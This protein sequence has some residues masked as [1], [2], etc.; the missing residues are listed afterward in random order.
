MRKIWL[1]SLIL[2]ACAAAPAGA[3]AA[4]EL[5]L[6]RSTV[7]AFR[8]DSSQVVRG[9]AVDI[10]HQALRSA[11]EEPEGRREIDLNLFPDTQL[12]VVIDRIAIDWP[13][14]KSFVG[15]VKGAA[16]SMVILVKGGGILAGKV[17]FPGKVFALRYAQE[18]TQVVEELDANAYPD[19]ELPLE[20]PVDPV[21][22]SSECDWQ[23]V[24]DG[25]LIDA[26][27][28]YDG[29]ARRRAGGTVAMRN[30]I[31]LAVA[32]ANEILANSNVVARISVVHMTEVAY[33]EGVS[34]SVLIR[35]LQDPADGVLDEVHGIRDR[36]G[37]DLVHF[38]GETTV[39]GCGRGYV[40]PRAST[41]FAP[42]AFAY[43]SRA[44][45]AGTFVV[46]HEMGH[47]M[48]CGHAPGDPGAFG[49]FRYSRGYKDP[50]QAFR[51]VM[52]YSCSSFCP[53]APYFSNPDVY[54]LG[55][56]T[57]RAVQ[58]NATSINEVASVV[59]NFRRR[60]PSSRP[61][62]VRPPTE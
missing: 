54:Y 58:N 39:G 50:Q 11:L 7:V 6:S 30:L 60:A 29:V 31:A 17:T 32:E 36:V 27:F 26:L 38:V 18:R 28:I 34:N 40:M 8:P 47:N 35:Q 25:T 51:T 52:A 15:H 45:F 24:D 1:S 9:R 42:Y 33:Q 20:A 3:A 2:L 56:P 4:R 49:T 61:D 19:E 12:T 62:G 43:S 59:A 46:A 48:G 23:Q 10:N 57:G 13:G 14:T 21:I 16:A 37:A 53:H 5:F 22:R 41:C 55:R 44:C